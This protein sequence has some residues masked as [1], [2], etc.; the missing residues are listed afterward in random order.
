MSEVAMEA[1]FAAYEAGD[2]QG[3]IDRLRDLIG[4]GKLGGGL[5]AALIKAA[6]DRFLSDPEAALKF[7]QMILALFGITVPLPSLPGSTTVQAV[8]WGADEGLA[9]LVD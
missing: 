4:G 7:I 1:V 8:G 2:R 6:F 3:V 9:A 5:L